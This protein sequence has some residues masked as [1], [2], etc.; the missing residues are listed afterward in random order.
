[1]INALPVR[2]R[3]LAS[4]RHCVLSTSAC[5]WFHGGRLRRVHPAFPVEDRNENRCIRRSIPFDGKAGVS[6]HVRDTLAYLDSLDRIVVEIAESE[7]ESLVI[8][9][10]LHVLPMIEAESLVMIFRG[11]RQHFGDVGV[12]FRHGVAGMGQHADTRSVQVTKH[13]AE[14][15]AFGLGRPASFRPRF[16]AQGRADQCA[17][18]VDIAIVLENVVDQLVDVFNKRCQPRGFSLRCA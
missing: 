13:L 18:L 1:M 9:G 14:P 16:F 15:V 4:Y 2:L 10:T 8:D 3:S 11:D 12:S 6:R 5:T 17:Q 7:H